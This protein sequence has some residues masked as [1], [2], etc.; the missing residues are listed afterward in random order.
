MQHRAEAGLPGSEALRHLILYGTF[1]II[2][3][4]KEE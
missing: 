2:C 4:V 1:D 3:I